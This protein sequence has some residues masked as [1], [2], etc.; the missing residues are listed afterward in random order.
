MILLASRPSPAPMGAAKCRTKKP[1]KVTAL[2]VWTRV[3]SLRRT[4]R[5]PFLLLFDAGVLDDDDMFVAIKL[6]VN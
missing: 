3:D 5:K 2:M 6:S 1:E 4:L